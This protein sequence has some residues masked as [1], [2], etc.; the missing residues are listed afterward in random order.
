MKKTLFSASA[1]TVTVATLLAVALVAFGG[2][3]HLRGKGPKGPGEMGDGQG[4][5]LTS[6]RL[7]PDEPGTEGMGGLG[8]GERGRLGAGRLGDPEYA[9]PRPKGEPQSRPELATVYFDFDRYEL[10][11]DAMATLRENAEWLKEHPE[12]TVHVE[13]HCDEWGTREYNFNLG[14]K[15]AESVILFLDKMGVDTARLVPVSYGEDRPV[16]VGY[17]EEHWS[18]NRRA[19][20][21]VFPD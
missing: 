19:E 2:C 13:G 15:R 10:R 14:E 5:R 4:D 21:K 17:G 7:G 12:T 3:R 16:S 20:F 9:R 18:K 8:D 1:R 6:H 11:P